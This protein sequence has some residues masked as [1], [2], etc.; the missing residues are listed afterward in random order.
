MFNFFIFLIYS[1][2]YPIKI[3]YSI[4]VTT[5]VFEGVIRRMFIFFNTMLPCFQLCI[6]IE[7]K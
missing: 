6:A 3:I 7:N 5:F 2:T 4:K 1:F